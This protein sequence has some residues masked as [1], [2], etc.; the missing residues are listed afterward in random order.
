MKSCPT[1]MRCVNTASIEAFMDAWPLVP[2][3][4]NPVKFKA[5]DKLRG[6]VATAASSWTTG[7]YLLIPSI[8]RIYIINISAYLLF[9]VNVDMLLVLPIVVK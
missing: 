2:G 8:P 6:G 7:T 3:I 9:L 4:I 1:T 5:S